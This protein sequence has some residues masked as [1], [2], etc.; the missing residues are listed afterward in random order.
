MKIIW[1]YLKPFRRWL[2][3][4]MGLAAAA[5][6]LQLFDPIIFGRIIDQ[7]AVNPGGRGQAELV[8]GALKW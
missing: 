6:V 2:W 1:T 3:L 4:A 8:R 5:Q 7:F